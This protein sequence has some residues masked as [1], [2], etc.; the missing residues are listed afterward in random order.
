MAGKVLIANRGEIAMRIARALRELSLPSVAIYTDADRGSLHVRHADEAVRVGEGR[1]DYL[2]AERIVATAQAV[3]AWGIHPGYG[4]LSESP[5]LAGACQRA[6]LVF[7][8]PPLSAIR[9]MGDK[10][11]ARQRM[12]D[13]GVPIVP[14]GPADTLEQASQSAAG[15]GYPVLLKAA[16]GGGG[17][18]MRRVNNATEL[19]RA[20]QR[21]R[22]EAE[23]SFGNG[24]VYIEKVIVGARHV[25]IQLLGD[26]H[27]N[28]VHLFER[29]C[30]LQRRHQ[31]IVEETPCPVLLDETREAMCRVALAGAR[32]IG[33]YSAGTFEFLL[34]PDQ[35]FHFLE[36]NTR[37]QV[38]HPITELTTGVDL[39]Q[40]MVRIA[41]GAPLS[42]GSVTR[43]GVAIEARIYAEDA[44]HGFLPAPG[45]IE[46]LAAPAGPFVRDDSGVSSGSQVSA[47]FDPLLSKLCA[48]G[49]TRA[50]A[51]SRLRR[52]LGEYRVL[53]VTTNLDFLERLLAHP[54][55]AS[56]D[57]HTQFV[58]ESPELTGNPETSEH[59]LHDALLLAALAAQADQR[60]APQ[61]T[62]E[63]PSRWREAVRER[64][65]R[66][67][68]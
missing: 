67:R 42:V 66:F 51:L 59:A 26:R 60:L 2:D 49:T 21:T 50:E 54:R 33:Y 19:Q 3:G 32:A 20:W 34:A 30:S 25:E 16:A 47:E 40:E 24:S 23:K 12:Q 46:Y 55:V 18:G 56:G 41:D 43:R 63:T 15:L 17:K 61:P 36:M 10:T 4:F 5:E 52:A 35:S 64:A 57:Y 8:G 65:T 38:E 58:E 53:G 29:D 14:G 6:G 48:W 62:S 27:G 9:E 31:K 11:R 22:S 45:R 37:L 28:L 7:I 39:V 44:A 68:S 13:A 1:G